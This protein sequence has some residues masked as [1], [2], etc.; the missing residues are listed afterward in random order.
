MAIEKIKEINNPAFK[1]GVSAKTGKQWTLM[2]VT[3]DK[4]N[5]TT[6]FAPAEV[7]DSLEL[8]WDATYGSWKANKVNAQQAGQLEALRKIYELNAAIYEAITGHKYGDV[9][10]IQAEPV[11]TA[12]AAPTKPVETNPHVGDTDIESEVDNFDMGSIP[13]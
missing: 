10:T 5:L 7:G 2:Q 1:T 9:P 8:T 12:P 6:V 11:K 13:F 4:N 3:T